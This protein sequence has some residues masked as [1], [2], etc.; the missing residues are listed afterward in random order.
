MEWSTPDGDVVR[1]GFHDELDREQASRRL[2]TALSLEG[3]WLVA[4]LVEAHERLDRLRRD[5]PTAGGLVIASD[6]DHAHGIGRFL[7]RRLGTTAEVVVSDDPGA[8][9]KIAAFATGTS[10]WLVAV[11]MVSESVDIPGLCVGVYATTTTTELFFRPAVGRFVR[12]EAGRRSQKAYGYVPDDPR[13]RAHAFQ[14]A[15]ARRH[16]LRPPSTD[17]PDVAAADQLDRPT[18]AD[19][20]LP[21]QLSLFTVVS[22]VATGV[23][24]H[25]YTETGLQRRR[26]KARPPGEQRRARQAARRSDRLEPLAGERRA[27]PDVGRGQ[28]GDRHDR[29]ARTAPP[30]RRELAAS[31]AGSDERSLG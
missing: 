12:W 13:L 30:L 23:Q 14:I 3:D 20:L 29:S 25:A 7:T 18:Y 2:R 11:R 9:H 4:V 6:Q 21:E 24:F 31:S 28:G 15:D 26:T 22:A 5:H 16:V 17:D 19:D 1:A 8:S 10:T 27:E